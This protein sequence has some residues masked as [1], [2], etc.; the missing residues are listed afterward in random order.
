MIEKKNP[1]FGTRL[2]LSFQLKV[3]LNVDELNEYHLVSI[4][5]VALFGGIHHI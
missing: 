3:L 2:R 5:L 4:N 1:P